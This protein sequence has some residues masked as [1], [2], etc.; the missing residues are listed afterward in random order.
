MD[1]KTKLKV[2]NT[3]FFMCYA[4]VCG[5]KST[6]FN[7]VKEQTKAEIYN[8]FFVSSDEIRSELAHD[9]QSKNKNLDYQTCFDKVGKETAIT[10]DKNIENAL[11]NVDENKINIILVDKNYPNGIDK[12]VGK[13]CTQKEK[14]FFFVFVPKINKPI[15]TNKYKRYFPFSYDYLAQC[16]LRLKSRKNHETLNGDSEES[17]NVFISFFALFGK[18][19]FEEGICRNNSY[20]NNVVIKTITFTD[21]SKNIVLDDQKLEKLTYRFTPFNKNSLISKKQDIDDF[22]KDIESNFSGNNYFQDTRNVMKEE[23]TSLLEDGI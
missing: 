12:F 5:G 17:K 23:V 8:V 3:Y 19:K 10:F 6:F 13:F 2:G 20:V 4:L 9:Y 14:H 22:L 1:S 18:F 16:Y 15:L 11:K 21:E 7:L